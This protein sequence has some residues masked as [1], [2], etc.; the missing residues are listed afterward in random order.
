MLDSN[1][2]RYGAYALTAAALV[3]AAWL[4]TEQR[5]F[6]AAIMAG[7]V[8]AAVLFALWRDRLPS[9]FTFAFALV[10]A[11][12]AAGYVFELW[13]NPAWFDE[14]VHVVTPFA[15]VAAV[16]WL[17][18]K[19]DS[20]HPRSNP[21]VYVLKILLIG[22]VVGIAWEGF[23]WL[24][25]I[26]GSWNDTLMDLL[27]DSIGALLAAGFCLAAARSDQTRIGS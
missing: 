25:G 19:R 5:W 7:F 17:L 21:A 16:G 8:A 4:A 10:A 13:R 9:L 27:M 1:A 23:E 3:A 26:A 14:A 6:E 2:F 12:N 24:I 15:I 20:A 11:I 22:I 18:V